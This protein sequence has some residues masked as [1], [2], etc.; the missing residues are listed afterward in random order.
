VEQVFLIYRDGR[1]ISYASFKDH[2]HMD[3]DIVG[4]MLNAIVNLIKSATVEGWEGKDHIES[5][6]ISFGEKRLI[7]E[8]R[9]SFFIAMVLHGKG[10]EPLQSQSEAVIDEIEEKYATAL[11]DWGGELRDFEGVDDLMLSLFPFDDLSEARRK[12]LREFGEKKS[13]FDIWSRMYHSILQ[14]GILPKP[15]MW[16]DFYLNIDAKKKKRKEKENEGT[17]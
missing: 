9:K 4:S 11:I 16:K 8:S 17:S 7:I 15:H 1:L 12:A 3:E 10:D 5:Y 13:I 14:E 6:K 2:G